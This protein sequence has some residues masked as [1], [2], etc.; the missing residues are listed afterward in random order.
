MFAVTADHLPDD[1]TDGSTRQYAKDSGA[2]GGFLFRC[3]VAGIL[4]YR[5]KFK[6]PRTAEAAKLPP[7]GAA[8]ALTRREV[9]VSVAIARLTFLPRVM[10]A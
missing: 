2:D 3:L 5:C 10:A 6:L 9:A 7:P 4:I 8:H 1:G